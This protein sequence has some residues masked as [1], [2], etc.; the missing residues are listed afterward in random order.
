MAALVT[1][2]NASPKEASG[3]IRWRAVVVIRPGKLAKKQIRKK[4]RKRRAG[5]VYS[6]MMSISTETIPRPSTKATRH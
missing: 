5:I 1:S 3:K 6:I 2:S 4:K